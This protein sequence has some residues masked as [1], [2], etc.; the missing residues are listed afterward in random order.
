MMVFVEESFIICRH[1]KNN[2]NYPNVADLH[3]FFIGYIANIRRHIHETEP[4]P[5][6]NCDTSTKSTF[7]PVVV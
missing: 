1:N 6:W 7:I 2:V 3:Y 5:I 4:L